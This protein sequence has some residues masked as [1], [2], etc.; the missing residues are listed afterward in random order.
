MWWIKIPGLLNQNGNFELLTSKSWR[1]PRTQKKNRWQVQM[2][3]FHNR[4]ILTLNQWWTKI[5]C[6]KCRNFTIFAECSIDSSIFPV[7]GLWGAPFHCAAPTINTYNERKIH[8]SMLKWFTLDF[9]HF[10]NSKFNDG[11]CHVLTLSKNLWGK[12]RI[13]V[14]LCWVINKMLIRP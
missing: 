5:F 2:K 10:T 13:I 6:E 7:S 8:F 11:F 1:R 4:K 9:L 12:S 3:K 14:L